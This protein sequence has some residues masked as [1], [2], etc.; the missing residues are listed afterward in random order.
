MTE[1]IYG[2]LS[3]LIGHW[4]GDKGLDI[5][6]LPVG[7]EV[8]PYFESISFEPIGLTT[9]AESQILA[10]L[11]YRQLVSR[12]SDSKVFH[13]QT[14]YWMWEEKTR[15]IFHTFVIP[16]GVC[17]LA[18]GQF[19]KSEQEASATRL[20]LSAKAGDADWGIIQSPFMHSTAQTLSY[21]ITLTVRGEFL[22][23]SQSTVL[24]I[25]DKTFTHTDD[26]TLRLQ[27]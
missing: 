2:P 21:E 12:K 10:G 23:Y 13:D 17:V 14:G 6:P 9:N 16:R 24:K 25:Y 11:Y 19:Q 5:S 8:N 4:Q 15:N 26:N 22:S 7:Q 27:K 3:A 18:G 1:T 20:Q